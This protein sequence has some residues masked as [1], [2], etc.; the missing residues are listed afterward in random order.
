MELE[1]WGSREGELYTDERSIWDVFFTVFGY[2]F[3]SIGA[4]LGAVAGSSRAMGVCP[5]QERS[6]N[7]EYFYCS[8][9]FFLLSEFFFI[10]AD[11]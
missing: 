3:Q 8:R 1:S 6:L 11:E 9:F 4:D 7:A 2:L 10:K 5:E